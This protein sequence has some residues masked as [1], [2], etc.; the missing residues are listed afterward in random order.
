[1]SREPSVA[2]VTGVSSGL[3][4]AIAIELGRHGA[5]VGLVARRRDRV[6]A[7]ANELRGLGARAHV[8]AGDLRDSAFAAR[9]VDDFV[10]QTDRL[11]LLVN[12]AGAPTPSNAE[13]A[14][15]EDFDA[16]MAE[17]LA[18]RAPFCDARGELLPKYRP[19][20]MVASFMRDAEDEA[21]ALTRT[22]IPVPKGPVEVW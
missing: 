3:G 6:E 12:N 16:A 18:W 2:L 17:Y 1:M 14:S 11:D 7:L 4:R 15:D 10:A 13:V 22:A 19:G 20:P 5:T 8:L 21:G 9:V